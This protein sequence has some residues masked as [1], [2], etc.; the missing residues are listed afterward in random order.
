MTHTHNPVIFIPGA[1]EY[2]SILLD[3]T[4]LFRKIKGESTCLQSLTY[5]DWRRLVSDGFSAE[6]LV[7]EL[8]DQ[9]VA[10]IPEGPVWIVGFSIGGHFAYASALRLQAMGREIAGLCVIDTYMVASAKLRPGWKKRNLQDVLRLWRQ[11]RLPE[12]GIFLREKLWRIQLRL[13]LSRSPALLRILARSKICDAFTALD[14]LLEPELSQYLLIRESAD[15]IASLD[16]DPVPLNAPS[17]LIRTQETAGDSSAWRRR[18]PNIETIDTDGDHSTVLH[19]D[20]AGSLRNA[21]V[22]AT[23]NWHLD[24]ENDAHESAVVAKG[25]R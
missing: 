16:R 13:L 2:V 24:T 7:S 22:A 9:I 4:A 3:L 12:L 10:K 15:W 14:P 8:V 18:C 23:R 20:Y 17:S 21:L 19:R 6:V 25:S 11:G 5:P 1:R